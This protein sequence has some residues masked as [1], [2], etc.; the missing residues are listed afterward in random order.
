MFWMFLAIV[1]VAAI[2]VQFLKLRE[3]QK[4]IRQAIERGQPLDDETVS[5]LL[6]ASRAPPPTPRGLAFIGL[7]FVCLGVGMALLGWF[8]SLDQP[9][10]LH[11]ALGVA[12]LLCMLGVPFLVG[13]LVA[14]RRDGAGGK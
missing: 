2:S 7:L 10:M 4:T 9:S 5:R 3:S 12:A 13:G 8:G 14:S 6:A 11:Q 1:V